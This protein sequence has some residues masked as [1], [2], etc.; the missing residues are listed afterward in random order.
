MKKEIFTDDNYKLWW[1]MRLTSD[2]MYK[3]RY[4]E[5][6]HHGITPREAAVLFVVDAIGKKATPAEISRWLLREPHSVSGI[7]NR[8]ETDGLIMKTKDLD[9]KN[10]IRVTMTRK[11]R[12]VYRLSMKR[13]V[14]DRIMS[15]LTA[16][17]RQQFQKLLDDLRARALKEFGGSTKLPFSK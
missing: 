14:V 3:A 1:L 5:L 12:L 8:M 6:Q 7:L 9:R 16:E 2:A 10:L 4:K 11:G 13:E 15:P 17:E